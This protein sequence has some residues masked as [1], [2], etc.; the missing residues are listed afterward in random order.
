MSLSRF[1]C[2]V[3]PHLMPSLSIIAM[4]TVK[5]IDSIHDENSAASAPY[6]RPRF[7]HRRPRYVRSHPTTLSND[8]CSY[9]RSPRENRHSLPTDK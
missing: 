8:E 2:L 6:Q 3:K 5:T 1:A 7:L 9:D 4:L